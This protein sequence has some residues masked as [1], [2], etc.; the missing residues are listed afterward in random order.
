MRNSLVKGMFA[1]ILLLS[2]AMAH[3]GLIFGTDGANTTI[4]LTSDIE[5]T[6]TGDSDFITRFVF[7]DAYSVIPGVQF[8]DVVSNTIGLK[9]NGVAIPTLNTPSVWGPLSF[10]LGEWDTND[11]TI[12]FTSSISFVTGDVV[13]LTAGTAVTNVPASLVPDLMPA[14]VMM[15]SN[16]AVSRSESVNISS[17]VEPV[18]APSVLALVMLAFC[19]MFARKF[20]A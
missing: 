13:T 14:T 19:G 16:S 6:A 11:F 15:V 7:E 10:N 2:G 9:L 3:A 17:V 8:N 5:F 20:K 4:T 12:S 1:G 18:S